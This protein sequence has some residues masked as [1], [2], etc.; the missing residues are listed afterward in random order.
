LPTVYSKLYVLLTMH[1][2]T[3]FVNNQLD[4]QFFFMYIYLYSLHVSN[5]YVSI[6]GRINCINTS[7]MSLSVDDLHRVTYITCRNDTINSPDDGHIAV[8]NM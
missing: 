6:I 7:G 8:Q 3:I 1:L 5:S 4:A 2:V